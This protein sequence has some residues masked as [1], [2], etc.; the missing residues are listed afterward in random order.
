[1]RDLSTR[2]GKRHIITDRFAV[3]VGTKTRQVA[4]R[5]AGEFGLRTQTHLNEQLGEKQ[6]VEKELYP[7]AASYAEVYRRDGLLDDQSVFETVSVRLA[8]PG[9]PLGTS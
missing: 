9:V 8:A 6:L 1:M 5:I 2:F 7:D 3:A 4:S